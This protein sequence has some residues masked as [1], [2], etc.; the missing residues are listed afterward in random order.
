MRISAIKTF[1][2]FALFYLNMSLLSYAQITIH[3]AKQKICIND[4]VLIRLA[5]VVVPNSTFTWQDS[6]ATG[7]N[8]IAPSSN[9]IGLTNDSIIIK[10]IGFVLNN[11]KYRCIVDSAGAGIRKDTIGKSLL[12]VR[13]PLTNPVI[14]ASQNICFGNTADTLRISQMPSGGDSGFSY[15]WQKSANNSI[16]QNIN[17]Q[18]DIKLA[19]DTFHASTYFRLVATSQSGCGVVNSSSVFIQFY[20]KLRGGHALSGIN[21]YV[22]CYQGNPDSIAVGINTGPSGGSGFFHNQWQISTDTLNWVDIPNDTTEVKSSVQSITSNVCYRLKSTSFAG[23][24]IVYSDTFYVRVLS[25]VIKPTISGSQTLCFDEEPD[26]IKI[27]ASP[28]LK[29]DVKF[30]WQSSINGTTWTDLAGKTGKELSLSKNGVTRFYRVKVT[31]AGCAVRYTDSVLV[32]VYQNLLA[33]TIKSSQNICYNSTPSTLSF[34]SL[35]TGGG[36]TY[37]YQWQISIDSVVFTDLPSAT[38]LVYSSTALTATRFY[39][40]KV[41]STAGCGTVYTNIIKVRV[42]PPFIGT[43]IKLNDTICYNTAPDTLRALNNPSGGNGQFLYQWQVSTNGFNWTNVNGQTDKKYKPSAIKVNTYYRLITFS[44]AGCGADTSNTVLIKVLPDITK[45]TIANHQF[46]CYNTPADTIRVILLAQGADQK[47]TYQWQI[48][49]NGTAWS[50][51]PGQ[52]TLKLFTGNLTTTKFYRVVASSVFGCGSVASDSVRIFV[53]D[54]FMGPTISQNQTICYDSIPKMLTIT[55]KPT[56]ANGLYF[57]QWQVSSDSINFTNIFAANDTVLQTGKHTSKKF[58]R[59]RVNSTLGCGSLFS[60]IIKIFV[61][62]KFEGA[63]IGRS[64]IICKGDVPK[65]LHTIKKPKGGSRIYLYQ[66][67][68]SADAIHW[69]DIVGHTEDSLVLA[70]V[71]NT[72]HYRMASTSTFGCGSDTSNVITIQTLSLPDTTRINGLFEVCKNQ[73]QLLYNLEN[74]SSL[75]E[76]E[77]EIEKGYIL[78]DE[79]KTN[80]FITWGVV[81][82]NDTIR[83]KQTNKITGCFN[84]MKLPVLIK[85]T[86][87]PNLTEIVRKSSTNILVSKDTTIGIHYQWGFID[88]QTKVQEDFPGATL[89]YIQLPHQFD[90][91]RYVYYVK[92]YFDDCVTTTYYNFDALSIGINSTKKNSL[93]IFPN[94]TSSSFEISGIDVS[95]ATIYCVD[96]LGHRIPITIDGKVISFEQ[97]QLPGI[98]IIIV[99]TVEGS[100]T[101]RIILSR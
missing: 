80:V 74:K 23:C 81:S 67:Q 89:R 16:W 69:E 5:N 19:I 61:Y 15:Q 63:E 76:Y 45:P 58:Y 28:L 39:R 94:P 46:I 97:N 38:D 53:Y 2:L 98:Y 4:S 20:E 95:Q 68:M 14:T 87:A 22:E 60:N 11:R 57:Y 17:S 24:G 44:A 51:I 33:G 41:V 6:T 82:G 21:H 50:N 48:S 40:V 90:T 7:W 52:N 29:N 31:W 86:F 101:N 10:N 96:V 34:Q 72:T 36:D 49:N 27:Q 93:K 25:P 99:N 66:W 100:F 91:T 70:N 43:D 8:N 77:W 84:Y 88:K 83:V 59:L 9:Y 85:E 62:D 54:Q 47:F 26:T 3:P 42:Y 12:L 32:S 65:T 79:S 18:T 13:A 71:Y 64:E 56:G 30:Q 75:Y 35:P 92:T 73:Q 37:T 78:T 55:A 1:V